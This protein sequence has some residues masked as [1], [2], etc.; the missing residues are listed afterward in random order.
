MYRNMIVIKRNMKKVFKDFL[1]ALLLA[2]V[3]ARF[4]TFDAYALPPIR[5]TVFGDSLMSG[6]QLQPEQAFPAK[7]E[8]KIKEYGF[9][10]VT[11]SDMSVPGETTAGGVERIDTVVAQR[12]DI[13]VLE[14][15]ANDAL[16]GINTGVIYNNLS[17][18]LSKLVQNQVYVVFIGN[19]APASMGYSYSVQLEQSYKTLADAYKVAFYPF[20]LAGVVGHP[21]L[22]L[23]DGYHPNARGVDIMVER[24]YPLVDAGLRTLWNNMA[25]QRE[26]Q[27][28]LQKT[29]QQP[30]SVAMPSAISRVESPQLV[31]IPPPLGGR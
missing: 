14:L 7:L 9:T 6:Y 17:T 20:A 31:P 11:V 13:V 23:A 4:S 30:G 2:G 19:K 16:R 5:I 12:P 28:Q 15:G 25:Y 29:M 26:Y 8:R 3:F 21:E 18:I 22:S 1:K 24:I 27:R 10:N